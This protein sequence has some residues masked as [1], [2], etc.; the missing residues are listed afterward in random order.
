MKTKKEKRP[1][2]LVRWGSGSHEALEDAD[3]FT[4]E[5]SAEMELS[6]DF[7]DEDATIRTDEGSDRAPGDLS[8]DF[9]DDDETHATVAHRKLVREK[10][11]DGTLEREFQTE[12][13]K[14]HGHFREDHPNGQRK[15][16]G[17]YLHGAMDGRWRFYEID[18][19]LSQELK[20]KNGQRL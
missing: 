11:A 20:F 14:R 12:N 1:K 15:S 18:G 10:R 7:S 8:Q 19:S 13:G 17:N 3:I 4:D 16:E 6:R 2:S 5:T 9:G